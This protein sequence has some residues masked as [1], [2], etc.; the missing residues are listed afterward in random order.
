M[1][2]NSP[3]DNLNFDNNDP[4]IIKSED[5]GLMSDTHVYHR[6]LLRLKMK[7][8]HETEI[9]DDLMLLNAQYDS[10]P[11]YKDSESYDDLL[12]SLNSSQS[13]VVES[14]DDLLPPLNSNGS[15]GDES[16]SFDSLLPPLGSI[17]SDVIDNFD[18]LLPSSVSE[19]ALNPEDDYKDLLPPKLQMFC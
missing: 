10:K 17:D 19:G 1:G 13:D 4:G 16:D 6:I 11:D 15:D 7:I 12:P 18:D 3:E 9:V 2:Q 14:Y 5:S 8:N